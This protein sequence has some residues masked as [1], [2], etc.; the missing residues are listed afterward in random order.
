MG[1]TKASHTTCVL[2]RVLIGNGAEIMRCIIE[3]W[4]PAE[5]GNCSILDGTLPVK[6]KNYLDA[7]KPEAVYFTVKDGQRTMIAVV[8]IPSEDKMVAMTEPLWLDWNASVS[9]TPA[10]SLADLQK[11]GKDMEKLAKDRQS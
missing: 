10:M 11:S 1:N 5:D 3:C 4:I 9:I 8:N 2:D 6:I 7:V